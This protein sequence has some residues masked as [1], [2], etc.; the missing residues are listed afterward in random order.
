MSKNRHFKHSLSRLPGGFLKAVM[1]TA[2][3]FLADGGN[4]AMGAVSVS[5]VTESAVNGKVSDAK[6]DAL[7]G[8]SVVIKGT[9]K[10]SITDASGK[11]SLQVPDSK[12]VLI[13]SYVG[14]ETKEVVVGNQKEINV[15]LE[16][17]ANTLQE[18]VV[19]GYGERKKE[20]L[21]GAIKQVGE[22]VFK[23]RPV[24]NAGLALQ[25]QVAGLAITRTS[26]RPGNEGL[27]IR[28]RGESSITGV[29]PL[30][31]VDGV[32]VLG[33]W[34]LNQINPSDIESV[35]VL[36]DAS[37]A[38]YGARAAGGVIL[39]KTKRG[40]G[41]KMQVSYNGNYRLNTIGITVPYANMSEWAKMY[42]EASL[43]DKVDANGNVVEWYPQ[44]GKDNVA[45]MALGQPFDF[46]NPGDQRV[47]R[48]ADNNWADQLY[49]P[50]FSQQ[51]NLSLRGSSNKSSYMFSIGY[52]DNKSVL[53]TAYDGEEKYNTRF[54]Y[55]YD[56]SKNI[57]LETGISY[58][59]R[60]VSAPKNGVGAGF[61]DAPV[62]PT[63]NNLGEYYDD[64]GYR[65]PVASTKSGGRDNNKEGILRLNSRIS[66]KLFDGFTLSAN[67]AVVNRQG[68][69]TR[70]NQTYK[71]YNWLGSLTTS[72]Q[73]PNP[74][75]IE[76]IANTNYETYGG[77]M[78]YVKTIAT[79][80]SIS[81]MAG[82]TSELSESKS[83]EA[84]RTKLE[85]DG[86]YDLN[87]ANSVTQTNAG[88]ASHWGLISYVGRFN[89]AFKEKY[90]FQAS[91][92]RDGSSK[93]H[94]DFRWSNFG[95]TSVGWR[96]SEENFIKDL[97]FFDN[98]KLR[99]GYG[100]T[101]GQANIGNYDYVS[102][103]TT[104]G[105]M[106]FGQVASLQQTS[107]LS[108]LTS[109]TRTWERIV[110]KNIGLEFAIL[111]NRL[112]GTAE[113]FEKRN[114]GMLIDITYPQ[115]LGGTAPKSNSGELKVSGW[116]IEL[117]WRDKIGNLRYHAGV[118]LSDNINR[119][120]SMQGKDSWAAGIVG[121]RQG[122]PLNSIFVYK[123][124]GYFKTSEEVNAYYAQY[125]TTSAGDLGKMTGETKRLRPGDLKRVDLDG[126]GFLDP[127]GGGKAGDGDVYYYGDAN[128]HYLFGVNLG[129]EWKG[130]SVSAF[131]QGVAKQNLLRSGN[132]RAPFFRNYL[133]VNNS[134]LGKT[135]TPENQEA[136]YPRISFDN[137]RNNWNWQ[138]NDVNVQNLSY[139]RL[140]SLVIGYSLPKSWSAK[141][142]SDNIRFYF[143]GND[144]FEMTSI[145][146]G[147]DP[148][149]GESSDS[150]Y[151]FLRT[152]S[153]GLDLSF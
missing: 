10:G 78:D 49:A 97:R 22:E 151:P 72:V 149:R 2:F 25:G 116:E 125:T 138:N 54:N 19:V 88:G 104:T 74:E 96:I 34:E 106:L 27:A 109:L 42:Q 40:K 3:I 50:A 20:S 119:L 31:I 100:E 132:A 135:W 105:T 57:K 115:V 60:T 140:K 85:Y 13:F 11:F 77:F 145:K 130:F 101:G 126:N 80:H 84:K 107:W 47:I 16:D 14:Y 102:G 24:S 114:K 111:N 33:T 44:W 45:K 75:I 152:W 23:D 41:D 66:A 71:L 38:I 91:G 56:L 46:V 95:E 29:D 21:T 139:A 61:F 51:Q 144:L 150:T 137:D 35:S 92:R 32:P 108:G 5:Q 146:D 131:I 53:K 76:N 153:L 17:D 124:D 9:T 142:K 6:G 65:N 121:Q 93:F 122:Y 36:K 28:L 1:L 141:I 118:Q 110:N 70:Y 63:Y 134:Y 86:L 128:P 89:Y 58:D 133:N 90:L 120:V 59:S 127:V 12:S 67:A 37:A 136:E 26:S 113:V 18:V 94:P 79:H 81:V 103:I 98:L 112:S 7:P 123:T 15:T 4:T 87:T 30:I 99:A 83:V 55:D 43:Q 48:Y 147:F 143:S 69:R 8:V 73:N 117:N 62:F 148:E 64:Y 39:V 82:M 68:W 129:A 52:A